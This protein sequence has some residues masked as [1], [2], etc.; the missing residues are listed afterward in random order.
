HRSLDGAV[1]EGGDGEESGT[2]LEAPRP[3]RGACT[4]LHGGLESPRLCALRAQRDRIGAR[5]STPRAGAR[6][7]SLQGARWA[8]PDLARDRPEKGCPQSLQAVAGDPPL[9]VGRPA[10]RRRAGPRGGRPG[11]LSRPAAWF[12]SSASAPP[13]QTRPAKTGVTGFAAPAWGFCA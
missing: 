13:A 10:T 6:S 2:R 3:H 8:R 9:L 7:Q 1:D 4:R 11:Y 12:F 5:G